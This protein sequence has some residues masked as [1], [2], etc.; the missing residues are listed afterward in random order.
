LFKM[1]IVIPIA[2]LFLLWKRWRFFAGFALSGVMVALISLEVFGVTQTAAYA[3]SLFSV[4][5][6]LAAGAS[7]FKVPLR[8]SIMANLRGL[9]SGLIG[10]RL[11]ALWIQGLTIGVS[12]LVLLSVARFAAR[13]LTGTDALAIAITTSVIVS[14]YLFMH[15]LSVLMIPIVITLNRFIDADTSS[16]A[17]DRVTAWMAAAVLVA[18]MFIFVIPGH[19]YLAALPLCAFL[20]ILM[21]NFLTSRDATIVFQE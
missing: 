16:S 14:Y 12:I 1:Q 2:L 8:V 4:G 17:L 9:I 20:V 3:R 11:P 5:S 15:D 10:G 6:G 13:K 21:W 7:Q 19:F 18:P